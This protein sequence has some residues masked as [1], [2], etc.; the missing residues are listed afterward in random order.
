MLEG[1]LLRRWRHRLIGAAPATDPEYV[2][3]G[4]ERERL[5]RMLD[6]RAALPVAQDGNFFFRKFTCVVS[7]PLSA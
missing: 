7:R 5:C 4:L 3:L 1:H 6:H 2:G